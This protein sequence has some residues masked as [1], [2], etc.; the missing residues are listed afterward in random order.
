[1]RLVRRRLRLR[2]ELYPLDEVR[3]ELLEVRDA[4]DVLKWNGKTSKKFYG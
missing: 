2:A 3:R 1:M 4:A